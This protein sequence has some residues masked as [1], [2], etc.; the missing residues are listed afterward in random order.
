MKRL[1]EVIQDLQSLQEQF[2]EDDPV[3]KLGTFTQYPPVV[4]TLIWKTGH[5]EVTISGEEFPIERWP[6]V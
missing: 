1:S 4:V 5:G 3:V 6:A 2:P